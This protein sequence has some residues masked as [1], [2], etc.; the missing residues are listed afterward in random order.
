[1]S[2][3]PPDD[4]FLRRVA[5]VGCRVTEDEIHHGPEEIARL[6]EDVPSEKEF[7]L[8]KRDIIQIQLLNMRERNEQFT[9]VL[10]EEE[11]A[12]VERRLE[13]RTIEPVRL[14]RDLAKAA[15]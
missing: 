15:A 12:D 10:N 13:D 9:G 1:M 5:A 4:E 14:F 6:A 7:E 11:L 3:L 8:A 2:Q